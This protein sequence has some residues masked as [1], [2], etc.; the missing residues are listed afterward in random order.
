LKNY[1]ITSNV[2]ISRSSWT[3]IQIKKEILLTLE[4]NIS[5]S[6]DGD[7]VINVGYTDT[8]DPERKQR[9]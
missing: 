8:K 2:N 5:R 4:F 9:R 3:F 1:K 7:L 6:K